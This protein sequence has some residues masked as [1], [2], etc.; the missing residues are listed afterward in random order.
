[1]H[2]MDPGMAQGQGERSRDEGK[3]HKDTPE[4][5]RLGQVLVR[6]GEPVGEAK[7]ICLQTAGRGAVHPG[8]HRLTL[9]R[10]LCTRLALA[11]PTRG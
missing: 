1:M 7:S 6:G 8:P 5:K 4:A 10:S 11:G 3:E 2:W 9:K